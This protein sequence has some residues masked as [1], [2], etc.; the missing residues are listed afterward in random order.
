VLAV[1]VRLADLAPDSASVP[2]DADLPVSPV[3]ATVVAV[4]R[5]AVRT[6]VAG[7]GQLWQHGG[8]AKH[9]A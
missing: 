2:D 3:G 6:G 8:D 9:E 1:R 5:G 4:V 7:A